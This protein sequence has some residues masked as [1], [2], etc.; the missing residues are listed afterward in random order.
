M[1]FRPYLIE[2]SGS[3]IAKERKN[4]TQSWV[5]GACRD[6]VTIRSLPGFYDEDRHAITG[7]LV[8]N[9]HK[10]AVPYAMYVAKG[11]VGVDE[12]ACPG[13]DLVCSPGFYPAFAYFHEYISEIREVLETPI[14]DKIRDLFYNGL[15]L[16]AFSVL[17]LFLCD[18]LLCGVFFKED[19]YEKAMVELQVPIFA[20]QFEVEKA[21][22]NE[23][24]HLVFHR[25]DDIMTLFSK[26]FDF[27]FPVYQELK[28]QIYRRHN[29]VHRFAISNQDRMTVCDAS[30]E[31]VVKLIDTIVCFVEDLKNLCGV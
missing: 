23:V 11:S 6:E 31:D 7:D 29:I 27:G 19:Y 22:R 20:D 16:G 21:I 15:Y 1:S 25:F 12:E 13:T 28:K 18:F 17:E 10:R 5:A 30:R 2:V 4:Y 24:Y 9:K 3:I 26:V 8:L 14:S